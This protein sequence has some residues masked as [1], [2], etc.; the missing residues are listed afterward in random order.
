MK[1]KASIMILERDGIIA[2]DIEN[3]LKKLGYAVPAIVF[4]GE[5]A[6]QKLEEI[7]P[8]L[9]L[10]EIELQGRMNGIAAAHQISTIHKIPVI[11]ITAISDRSTIEQAKIVEPYGFIIKPFEED[12]LHATLE[13]ALHKHRTQMNRTHKEERKIK[14]ARRSESH[15]TSEAGLQADWTRATFIVR[16]ENL[17]KIKALA[18]WER[19]KVKEIID[20]A[21]DNY[22]EGKTIE[23]DKV[24]S[25]KNVT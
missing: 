6:L 24:T 7:K 8:D 15:K 17:E 5:E 9:V 22:L 23:L 13:M 19:K 2:A 25:G 14:S 4:S 20:E 11:F 1:E 16:K 10:S 18:Y 21:L 3:I 12:L